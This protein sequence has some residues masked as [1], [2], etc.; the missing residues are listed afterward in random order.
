MG[1]HVDPLYSA[2]WERALRTLWQGFIADGLM[3]AG[4]SGLELL[5]AGSVDLASGAFWITLG[6]LFA[7]SLLVSFLSYLARIKI[8]PK[9]E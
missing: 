4:L 1:N 3:M 5:R 9:N 7:K 6:M 8:P 2:A